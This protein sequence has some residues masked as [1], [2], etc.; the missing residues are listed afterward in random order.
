MKRLSDEAIQKLQTEMA[1]ASQ[2]AW[3]RWYSEHCWQEC[4][5]EFPM[6]ELMNEGIAGY[7]WTWAMQGRMTIGP[8]EKGDRF[9]TQGLEGK[10]SVEVSLITGLLAYRELPE[11]RRALFAL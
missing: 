9:G 5:L 8:I 6:G 2:N 11:H 10:V 7:L 1:E 3:D 4:I